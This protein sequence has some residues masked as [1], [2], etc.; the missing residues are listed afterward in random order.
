MFELA[1]CLDL[2]C[3]HMSIAI[4]LLEVKDFNSYFF[5]KVLVISKVYRAE[6]AFTK[7]FLFLYQFHP[8]LMVKS[9]SSE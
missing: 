9:L 3:K 7:L 6:A 4:V 2:L 1:K 5:V 8:N